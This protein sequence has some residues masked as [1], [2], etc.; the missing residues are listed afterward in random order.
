VDVISIVVIG[1]GVSM[2]CLAVSIAGSISM[3][4]VSRLKALR[5]S[6]SFGLFQAGMLVMGWL[7]GQTVVELVESYA[8]WVAFGLLA[9][10]AA[11]MV[12]E[13]FEKGEDAKRV[14]ITWGLALLTLSVA[15]SIDSLAVGLGLAFLESRVL[16]AA[17]VIGS[18]TFAISLA[19]FYAGG[20]I[21]RSLGRWA[22]VTG[23]VVLLAIGLRILLTE[24]L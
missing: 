11:R 4:R 10:V 7:L 17:P 9:L 1:L 18:I 6:F 3:R 23:A 8:P 16:L 2:D 21:G 19:G 13:S 5:A 14:D 20:R 12:R 15:T 22:H 24:V